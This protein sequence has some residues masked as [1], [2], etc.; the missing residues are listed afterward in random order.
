MSTGKHRGE[1][2]S[3]V[4]PGLVSVFQTNGRMVLLFPGDG[5]PVPPQT[6]ASLCHQD[7]LP[8]QGL[9]R[10]FWGPRFLPMRTSPAA[11]GEGLFWMLSGGVPVKGSSWELRELRFRAG[12]LTQKTK[13]SNPE[14]MTDSPRVSLPSAPTGKCAVP[15]PSPAVSSRWLSLRA[16]GEEPGCT[17]SSPVFHA[18]AQ[19]SVHPS[20]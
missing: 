14:T 11:G 7:G 2:G 10:V 8:C 12:S 3:L 20:R 15:P 6:Q 13:E 19:P 16:S 5:Q 17:G 4:P 9:S 18:W 1:R